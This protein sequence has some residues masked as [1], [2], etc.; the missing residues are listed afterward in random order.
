MSEMLSKR[1]HAVKD[2][3][4]AA[5][6]SRTAAGDAFTSFVVQVARLGAEFT[7]IG[8]HLAALGDLTLAHWVVLDAAD[9]GPFSVAQIARRLG[10]AR[11]S[12]QRIADLLARDG[13]AVYADNPDHRRAKL[14]RPTAAGRRVV[15]KI[16]A[17]QKGWADALGAEIGEAE[18][19]ASSDLLRRIQRLAADSEH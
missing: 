4:T 13:M 11:Q 10:L 19:H 7:A 17:A 2:E 9:D 3:T 12:V 15:I 5:R 1:Q 18:L 14:L 8:E 6:P 16:A